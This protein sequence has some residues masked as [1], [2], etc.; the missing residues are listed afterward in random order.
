MVPETWVPCPLPSVFWPETKVLRK[1]ARPSN[2]YIKALCQLL[3]FSH[4]IFLK[5]RASRTG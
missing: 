5:V 1:V 3:V 4:V 2:S